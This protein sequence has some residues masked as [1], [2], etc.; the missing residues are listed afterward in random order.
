MGWTEAEEKKMVKACVESQKSAKQKGCGKRDG[1]KRKSLMKKYSARGREMHW[2][3][4][5]RYI[6]TF[7]VAK[8]GV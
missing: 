6:Y 8:S 4:R 2:P 5:S 3:V 7:L 1:G